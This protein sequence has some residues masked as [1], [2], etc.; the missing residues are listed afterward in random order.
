[1]LVEHGKASPAVRAIANAKL[2]RRLPS[3]AMPSPATYP[4]GQAITPPPQRYQ[5]RDEL[6]EA[7]RKGGSDALA[8]YYEEIPPQHL[9]AFQA[10]RSLLV[11]PNAQNR[12]TED[13]VRQFAARYRDLNS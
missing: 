9:A 1:M 4:N 3:V 13:I 12:K 10:F 8:R 11:R 6:E 2:Q 5:L 7:Y